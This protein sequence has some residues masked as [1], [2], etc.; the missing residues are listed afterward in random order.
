MDRKAPQ[1][2]AVRNVSRRGGSLQITVPSE[3]VEIMKISNG[4]R[5]A[6]YYDFNTKSIRLGKVPKIDIKKI[7]ELEFAVSKE[8]YEKI[9]SKK[10]ETNK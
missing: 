2:I 8:L 5:I 1:I 7:A 4:D 6:F 9:V 3:V 10:I